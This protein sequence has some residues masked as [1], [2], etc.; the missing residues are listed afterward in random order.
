MA[1]IKVKDLAYGRLRSPDL[2]AAEEFLTHFGMI[3][4]AQGLAPA[5]ESALH[6]SLQVIASTEY[7]LAKADAAF[8]LASFLA[9]QARFDEAKALCDEY[10][11]LTEQWGWNQW[12]AQIADIR[13][14]IAAGQRTSVDT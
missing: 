14:L 5:A 12:A 8:D 13:R 10:V 1:L 4:A 3:R 9:G 11:A 7:E 6:H 2:D